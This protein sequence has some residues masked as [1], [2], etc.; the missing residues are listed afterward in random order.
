MTEEEKIKAFAQKVILTQTGKR[1]DVDDIEG[2]EGEAYLEALVDWVNLFTGELELEADWQY[3]RENEATIGLISSYDN[4][5]EL[6]AGVRKLIVNENRNLLIKQ[7]DA[8]VSVW[9]IVSPNII[10]QRQEDPYRGRVATINNKVVFSRPLTDDELGGTVHA[11]VIHTMPQLALNDATIIE[12]IKPTRLLV[13]GVAKDATLPDFVRG[14]ISPSLAQKYADLLDKAVEENDA[15]AL[16]A[17]IIVED[18][19]RLRGVY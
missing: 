15:S 13:L 10:T 12:T 4:M 6:P 17:D 18:F 9:D 7:G 8:I 19:G 11:D 1:M 5:I 14:G 2:E 3:L 16:A